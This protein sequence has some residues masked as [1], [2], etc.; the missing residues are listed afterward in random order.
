MG[1]IWL[2]FTRVVV[3]RNFAGKYIANLLDNV[4]GGFFIGNTT[5]ERN[6]GAL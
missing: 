1:Q 6:F 5:L 3:N 2:R 4:N